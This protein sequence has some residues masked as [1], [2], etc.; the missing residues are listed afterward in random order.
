MELPGIE[1]GSAKLPEHPLRAYPSLDLAPLCKETQFSQSSL[2]FSRS[3][4]SSPSGFTPTLLPG[5]SRLSMDQAAM[6][7]S[8]ALSFA[9][10]TA[11]WLIGRRALPTR[12]CS[13][14]L[15]VETRSAPQ[16]GREESNLHGY[17]DPPAPQAG[18]AT[19]TPRPR[20]RERSRTS[21]GIRSHCVLSAARLPL[22]HSRLPGTG[23][24]PAESES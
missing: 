19:V 9:A 22:R 12:R 8:V 10:S 13:F 18:A 23:I 15:H 1:P 3:R 24:E 16:C 21:T 5:R 20:A 4:G 6:A 11:R 14:V 7:W 2:G 17:Y